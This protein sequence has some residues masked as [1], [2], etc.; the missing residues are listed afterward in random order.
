MNRIET[1]RQRQRECDNNNDPHG[2][3]HQKQNGGSE[4]EFSG[5]VAV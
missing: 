1:Q 5:K 3:H 4:I 2:D